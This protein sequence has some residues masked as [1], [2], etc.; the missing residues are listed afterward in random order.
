MP[1]MTA[2]NQNSLHIVVIGW[3]YIFNNNNKYWIM[4]IM[5]S[6]QYPITKHD[7]AVWW[8]WSTILPAR[9][10]LPVDWNCCPRTQ[11]SDKVQDHASSIGNV[12]SVQFPPNIQAVSRPC[13]CYW[14]GSRQQQQHHSFIFVSIL[15][16]WSSISLVLNPLVGC[17]ASCHC[18]RRHCRHTRRVYHCHHHDCVFFCRGHRS[19]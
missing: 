6:F 13:Y 14:F 19:R 5:K 11:M 15:R 3:W 18:P 10:L 12:D 16:P 9:R 8:W 4:I 1:K 2:Q 17:N 7:A